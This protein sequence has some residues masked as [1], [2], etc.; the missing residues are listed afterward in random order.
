M[1]HA[2]YSFFL[3]F[4]FRAAHVFTRFTAFVIWMNVFRPRTA[5]ADVFCRFRLVFF[6]FCASR[7]DEND[8]DGRYCHNLRWYPDRIALSFSVAIEFSID[9]NAGVAPLGL[10][11]HL[12]EADVKIWSPASHRRVMLLCHTR[13]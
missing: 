8:A 13:L 7:E 4:R 11:M 5:F 6:C 9:T 12:I 10:W 3:S 2:K 1:L